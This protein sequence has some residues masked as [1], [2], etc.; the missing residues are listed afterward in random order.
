MASFWNR[1]ELSENILRVLFEGGAAG[2]E[3]FADAILLKHG[4]LGAG[5]LLF[6][7]GLN[8]YQALQKRLF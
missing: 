4:R 8:F 7:S 3:I 5:V 2:V 6:G 1:S